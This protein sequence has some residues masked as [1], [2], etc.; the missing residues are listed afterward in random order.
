MSS[1]IDSVVD[2]NSYSVGLFAFYQT[3]KRK[4]RLTRLGLYGRLDAGWHGFHAVPAGDWD[5]GER[6]GDGSRDGG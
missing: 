2:E 3:M 6:L 1:V 4:G 5:P